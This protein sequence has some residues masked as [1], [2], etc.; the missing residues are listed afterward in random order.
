MSAGRR[1]IS[2]ALIEWTV[3]QRG[4]SYQLR[5]GRRARAEPLS[6]EDNVA[7]NSASQNPPIIAQ[8]LQQD[9]SLGV[10]SCVSQAILYVC[11]EDLVVSILGVIEPSSVSLCLGIELDALFFVD[12][13]FVAELGC[14]MCQVGQAVSLL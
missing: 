9:V 6:L 8:S 3:I 14:V 4:V 11:L 7:I 10:Y 13:G 5:G 1:L 12:L 2:K